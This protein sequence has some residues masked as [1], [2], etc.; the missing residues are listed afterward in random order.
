MGVT[1]LDCPLER[2]SLSVIQIDADKLQGHSLRRLVC[3]AYGRI[4][5]KVI[6]DAGL[7]VL[8]LSHFYYPTAPITEDVDHVVAHA[9]WWTRESDQ[10][11]LPAESDG[12][13]DFGDHC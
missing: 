5:F 13:L 8:R 10:V 12:S 7:Y 1:F 3:G 9:F 4:T 2:Q 11:P 6:F